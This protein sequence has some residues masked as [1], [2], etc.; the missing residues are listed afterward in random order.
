MTKTGKSSAYWSDI[1]HRYAQGTFQFSTGKRP[2][3]RKWKEALERIDA[4]PLQRGNK[5]DLFG[6]HIACTCGFHKSTD[7][8][9]NEAGLNVEAGSSSEEAGTSQGEQGVKCSLCR[10][11]V[12]AEK[13]SE[14]LSDHH[15]EESCNSCGARV[16]GAV[17]LLQHIESSHYGALLAPRVHPS[18]NPTPSPQLPP[19]PQHLPSPLPAPV[20]SSLWPSP[21]PCHSAAPRPSPPLPQRSPSPQPTPSSRPAPSQH[22]IPSL[23]QAVT[24]WESFLPSQFKRVLQPADWV[25]IAKCLY[26]S[27]G[28][29]RQKIP[30]NWFY[31]PMQPK[32]SPPEPGWY[33]RQRMF[34]WAPMRMWGIPLK[35]P[36]C[37]QKMHHSG[38]Y[39]KVREV[40]DMDN[41]YYLVGGDYPRCS[42]C[43]LPVCP[44]SQDILSQL[45]VAHRALFPAMLTTQLALDRKCVTFLRPRTS[46]NSSSYLQSAVEEVHSEEWARRTIQYLSD[47]EHHLRKF[48]L[49]QS[50]TAPAFS[51]PAPFRPLPL[52]QWFET[53]HSNNILSHL[54]EMKGVI[55]STYGRILKM[56]STKK[57]TKKL[58]GGI[59]DTAAWMTNIGNELGQVLNSVLTTGEGAGLEELC[60]GVVRRYQNAG[61]PEPEVIYVDRDCCSQSGW[62][63]NA[64][65]TQMYMLE[66]ASRWNMSRAKEAVSVVGASTLR[67][68]D[69][70]LMSHLNNMSQRVLGQALMPEFTPPGKPTGERI[71]VEY[72]LAQSN[73]GDQLIVHHHDMPEVSPEEPEDEIETTVCHAAD[74]RADD[75]DPQVAV[76]EASCQVGDTGPKSPD[77]EVTEEEEN[78]TASPSTSGQSKQR[79]SRGVSGWEAVDALAAYLVGL[80]RTI[81]A[82][83]SQEEANIVQLHMALHAMDK[84]P[85]KY[86]QRVKKKTLPGPWRASRKRS[87]SAPGQQ[88]AERLF[89]THGQAAQNPEVHRVCECVCLRLLKECQQARNRPKDTQGK[90]LPIPQSIVV[91]YSHLKQLL[92]DS[93]AV[94]GQTNLV[95]VPINTTTVS[96]CSP[97]CPVFGRVVKAMDLKSIGVSPRRFK[98]CRLWLLCFRRSH[99]RTYSFASRFVAST[100]VMHGVEHTPDREH[101]VLLDKGVSLSAEGYLW[102]SSGALATPPSSKFIESGLEIIKNKKIEIQ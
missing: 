73:R 37:G 15:V 7:K 69:V 68:F 76:V 12:E 101:F 52:A 33:F 74:L 87:G 90:T 89:M 79:D 88:A 78:D 77:E 22:P 24:D 21:S 20:S 75:S 82:L 6:R 42:A 99:C 60:Q 53:V 45:D 54:D 41:R 38:I 3:S 100:Q 93:R 40:I 71:A 96:S 13:F 55:T 34:Y 35:C 95:M 14:H 10:V 29:L 16:Q 19:P 2:G 61:E 85:S 32:P 97:F 1:C 51:A 25:W 44:W 56:D 58:A 59:G 26:E 23:P 67:T 80:N 17:G 9:L 28:Q 84:M 63:C 62:R 5:V 46:G 72:L 66:G 86:S 11:F 102:Q 30:A 98:P 81:T 94:L 27:T 18:K 4:F 8:A 31:P 48:A 92:E 65:H 57:I 83:S 91:V 36:Q 70:C 39:P 64:M 49:V 47:C 50:A 43:K